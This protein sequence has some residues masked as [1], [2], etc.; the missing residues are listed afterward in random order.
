M[1]SVVDYIKE[2]IKNLVPYEVPQINCP[3][4]L[5]ANENPYDLPADFKERIKKILDSIEFN[6]YPDPTCK[7]LRT[8]LSHR[9]RVRDDQI[10]IGNGSDELIQSILLTFGGKKRRVIYPVPTFGMYKI[11]AKITECEIVEIPLLSNDFDLNEEEIIQA[12]KA[13]DFSIVFLSYPNNPTS[14][15]FSEE[16][17]K[18]ILVESNGLVVIDE[19][20]FEFSGKTNIQYIH[21]FENL[22]VLRTFSKAFSMAALR[23]GYLIGQSSVVKE[24]SKVKLP[25]NVGTF[26]QAVAYTLL[27]EA[28]SLENKIKTI[29]LER[30]RLFSFLSKFP[31]IN[32]FP[33]EANFILFKTKDVSADHLYSYLLC[34]GILIRNLSKEPLLTNCLRLTVG[35]PQENG[36]FMEVIKRF[37]MD[38]NIANISSCG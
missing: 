21:E 9:L 36:R 34:Q 12:T 30:R 35:T 14:N 28:P 32:L 7:D 10:L 23:I 29:L 38:P 16:K 37:L 25:Y 13:N 8:V 18:K 6:R 20:Y 33:T 31:Q 27:L 24:I 3:I 19:A 2:N 15:C 1:K 22:L 17:I 11:L 5:D 26:P 4:K